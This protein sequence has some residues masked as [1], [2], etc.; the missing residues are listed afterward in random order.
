MLLAWEFINNEQ[1]DQQRGKHIQTFKLKI[2]SIMFS[3]PQKRKK[4]RFSIIK[5]F[6]TH[7]KVFHLY[8]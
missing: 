1:F 6:L 5:S 2:I 4:N 8:G 3:I 7:D